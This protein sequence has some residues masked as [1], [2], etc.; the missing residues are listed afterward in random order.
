MTKHS[1]AA[2]CALTLA[3]FGFAAT[4]SAAGL[5]EVEAD[6]VARDGIGHLQFLPLFL[7]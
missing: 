3:S 1:I 7:F 2:F 5:F 6:M 4:S